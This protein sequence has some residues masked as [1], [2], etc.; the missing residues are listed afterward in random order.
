MIHVSQEYLQSLTEVEEDTSGKSTVDGLGSESLLL[1]ELLSGG[2]G[3]CY[4][5]VRLFIYSM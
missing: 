4:K 5:N 1:L 3:R 2:R